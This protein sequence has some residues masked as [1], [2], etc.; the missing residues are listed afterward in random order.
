[1]KVVAA[2]DASPTA[3]R[4]LEVAP[5]IA[6][7]F[8]AGAEALHVDEGESATARAAAG[9][10]GFPLAVVSGPPVERLVAA[11]AAGEVAA[12]VLGAR[13]APADG[14]PPGHTALEVITALGKPIVVVPGATPTPFRLRRALVPHDG[15]PATAT[16]LHETIRLTRRA[17]VELVVL[18]VHDPL[19]LPLFTDQP[20]HEHASF[21]RE[22]LAR[23]CSA[24]PADELTFE[25]RVGD[26]AEHCLRLSALHDVDLV[27][28]AWSRNLSG[29][30][31]DVVRELLARSLVP[32]LLIPIEADD[33]P[34]GASRGRSR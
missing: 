27:A 29:G 11:G 14:Q 6:R 34:A 31:G 19:H 25:W 32:V 7:L 1:M 23:S 24:C 13:G 26:P 3:R 33:D 2:I 12:L 28:L 20:Q 16:A 15:T 30:R 8:G 21:E 22:F 9:T 17:G 5:S 4:V 18:H 10:A